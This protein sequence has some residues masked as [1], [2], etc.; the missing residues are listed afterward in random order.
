LYT[1]EPALYGLLLSR[2][3]TSDS[4]QYLFDALGSTDRL[5]DD[6]Q[7]PI[8]HYIYDAFGSIRDTESGIFQSYMW[9]GRLGYVFAN[10]PGDDFYYVRA[11]N[12]WPKLGRWVSRDP[13]GFAGGSWNLYDYVGGRPI[14]LID[15][16]GHEVHCPCSGT[17]SDVRK[18]DEKE[19][20]LSGSVRV[21]TIYCK[22]G[23][24]IPVFV[25][26]PSRFDP[27]EAECLLEHERQHIEQQN[28]WCPTFCSNPEH[29]GGVAGIPYIF[30]GA[31]YEESTNFLECDAYSRELSCLNQKLKAGTAHCNPHRIRARIEEIINVQMPRYKCHLRR[32]PPLLPP[33]PQRLPRVPD[34]PQRLPQPPIFGPP[35]LPPPSSP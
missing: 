12:Y 1:R 3:E 25:V 11:R 10:D 19:N 18:R 7:T 4:Y 24:L 22:G 28:Y 2:Q 33:P 27:C 9:I 32:L 21:A 35:P 6:T 13:I 34:Q 29:E 23:K 31:L 30:R 16:S 17:L 15:P 8:E 5:L 26:D 14:S 20:T